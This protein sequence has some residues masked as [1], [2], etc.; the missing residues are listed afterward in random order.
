MSVNE[1]LG[2]CFALILLAGAAFTD[3]AQAFPYQPQHGERW[4]YDILFRGDDVGDISIAFTRDD[5]GTLT[6][7]STTQA[8]IKVAFVTVFRME[9]EAVETWQGR[10]LQSMSFTSETNGEKQWGKIHRAA[11]GKLM[12]EG[13][14]GRQALAGHMV[15]LASWT[16]Y[17]L[18]RKRFIR[19]LENDVIDVD[20]TR[21]RWENV[22]ADGATTRALR[23]HFPV[24]E[25]GNQSDIWYDKQRR[26][27][28]TVLTTPAATLAF[29]RRRISLPAA[30]SK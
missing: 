14:N 26:F 4:E 11:E 25:A 12:S 15:H 10:R 18:L 22:P 19:P 8:R 30:G 27:V 13:P 9:S 16:P 2:L 7:R 6:V 21:G 17:I 28:R 29:E 1:R 23:F 5:E 20:I 24:D 3:T